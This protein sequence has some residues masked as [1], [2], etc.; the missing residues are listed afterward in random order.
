[1]S[2]YNYHGALTAGVA[3]NIDPSSLRTNERD[4]VNAV[5][6]MQRLENSTGTD[7]DHVRLAVAGEYFQEKSGGLFDQFKSLLCNNPESSTQV[8]ND[9]FAGFASGRKAEKPESILTALT[10]AQRSFGENFDCST[11]AAVIKMMMM[12]FGV[13]PEDM[14]KDVKHSVDGYT[15]T[16]KDDFKVQLTHEELQAATGSSKFAG[17]DS[18]VI[19]SANFMFAAFVKRKQLTNGNGSFNEALLK[20]LQGET[21]KRCLE[22]MGMYG[23]SQFVPVSHMQSQ[24]SVGVVG[25]HNFGSDLVLGGIRY[26]GSKARSLDRTYGYMLFNDKSRPD[27]QVLNDN[28]TAVNLSPVPVGIKPVDIWGG[29]YQGSDGNCV[30]VSAIKAAMMRFGQNPEGIFNSIT[31]TVDGYEVTMRDSFTLQLSHEEL[32]KAKS[33]SDLKGNDQAL[34]ADAN[35]LYAVSAKRAQLEDN[36]FRAKH[37]FEAAMQTLNDGEAPGEALR[38]LGLFGYIRASTT[39]ELA[40]GAIGTLADNA[41]SVVVIDGAFDLYGRKYDLASSSWMNN[42]VWALKLV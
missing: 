15:I 28:K 19:K 20:T 7:V 9:D 5:N 2:V 4:G 27:S 13:N 6:E 40:G 3:L 8:V 32:R 39:Q 1:M 42:G 25:S 41:H 26:D 11:H 22:G 12:T 35:F 34:L 29:F 14:F 38:R 16:M 23:H 37:S 33:G 36:D 21:T 18:D 31:E 30:T 24:G 17:S 10:V